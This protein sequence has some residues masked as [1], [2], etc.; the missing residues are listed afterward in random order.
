[1]SAFGEIRDKIELANDKAL[2]ADGFEDALIGYVEIFS[3]T[4]ALYDKEKCLEILQKRDG[5]TR[6][7]ALEFFEFNVQGSYHGEDT[8]GFATILK[9]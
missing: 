3:R 4:I 5:M 7:D 1:M 9:R 2:L 8:P 6:E